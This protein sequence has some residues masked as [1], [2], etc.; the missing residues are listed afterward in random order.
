[1]SQADRFLRACR[2]ETVDVTPI[3]L[4]RQAGR[5]MVEY[6]ALRER[7]SIL[8]LIKTPDLAT[9]VTLQPIRVFKLDAAIIFSDILPILTG[10][11]MAI[12]FVKGDGP[13]IHN[14]L[15]TAADVE[16][17]T[18]QP[19]ETTL[20][21][22]LEAIKQVKGELAGKIPLIGFSGAPFTLASYAIE[23]GS[24]RNYLKT[25]ALMY[26]QPQTWHSLME[27]LAQTV[28]GYL[29]AQVE[30]GVDALQLF[31]SWAGA[32]SPADYREYVLP[33]SH[34]AIELAKGGGDVSFIH[35]STGT[36]GM[37]PA[38]KEAGGDVISIDWRIELAEADRQLGSEVALQGNLDPV[39]LLAPIAEIKKQAARILES[40]KG[41]QGYIFNLGHGI[42][43]QTP[44]DH[45]A[46]LIDFVHE[47]E[48]R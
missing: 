46:A 35:F 13:V 1:M 16:A 14:P 34:Q 28:G 48:A 45:V 2:R 36:A 7:F 17:L 15:Q 10:L 20:S 43:P 11:G 39:V 22:T 3:W 23:G 30:A 37:L 12:D 18:L 31:D 4:M 9:E 24:S 29:R 38:I 32:L 19:A 40:V 6:R 21:F 47:Y 44:V 41:R 27:K 5:Y 8:E 26:E 33:Y 42:L 25:K